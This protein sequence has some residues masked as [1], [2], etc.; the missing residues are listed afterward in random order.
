MARALARI[1]AFVRLGRPHYLVP[2]FVLY[3]LGAAMAAHPGAHLDWTVFGWGQIA[4]TSTQFMTHYSNDYFDLEADRANSTPTRWSGG[5]RVLPNGELPPS[6]ALVAALVLGVIALGATAVLHFRLNAPLAGTALLLLA[7]P[8]AWE[9]SAPPLRLHS[10]GLGELTTVVVVAGLTPLAAYA[11]QTGQIAAAALAALAPIA[12]LTF[13]LLLAIEFP[14]AVG[15]AAVG[16][17]TLVVRLGAPLAARLYLAT[18]LAAYLLIPL[19]VAAGLATAVA[20]AALAACPIAVVQVWRTARGAHR[21]PARWETFTSLAMALVVLTA[22][23][24]LVA[25][26]ALACAPG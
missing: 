13:A 17:R 7:L 15:D 22:T 12:C 6:A 21:V 24:E 11:L 4:I 14:D 19:I 1:T 10:R 18:M 23:A 3:G 25:F 2:G 9:Y 16:K 26:I 20:V 5:S 8:L